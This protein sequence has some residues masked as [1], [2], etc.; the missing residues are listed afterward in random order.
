MGAG[1]FID[2]MARGMQFKMQYDLSKNNMDLLAKQIDMQEAKLKDPLYIRQQE[3]MTKGLELDL[4]IKQSKIDAFNK[5]GAGGG[6]GNPA[7]KTGLMNNFETLKGNASLILTNPEEAKRYMADLGNIA[8][9]MNGVD[10][11]G[12]PYFTESERAKVADFTTNLKYYAFLQHAD[13]LKSTEKTEEMTQYANQLKDPDTVKKMGLTIEQANKLRSAYDVGSTVTPKMLI[14]QEEIEGSMKSWNIDKKTGVPLKMNTT[15]IDNKIQEIQGLYSQGKVSDSF[16]ASKMSTLK[17]YAIKMDMNNVGVAKGEGGWFNKKYSS[18]AQVT[19]TMADGM[20]P[21]S[22]KND[23]GAWEDR[24]DY[25]KIV[26]DQLMA[27]GI[28]LSSTNPTD[29][30]KAK[31]ITNQTM[32]YIMQ[33]KGYKPLKNESLE[34][35]Q[36]RE[37]I[38]LRSEQAKQGEKVEDVLISDKLNPMESMIRTGLT[39]GGG[40][41]ISPPDFQIN[42]TK[43]KVGK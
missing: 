35:P 37:N 8:K 32:A 15:D 10:I 3:A 7:M 36:D 12:K 20:I 40:I 19:L 23:M 34:N 27:N 5:Q 29:V 16:Y 30:E 6:L 2:G 4:Q 21:R 28:S 18:V 39:G 9:Q 26:N 31:G 17:G 1:Y 41:N 11:E 22:K 33:N 24:Y 14:T 13:T 42:K 43:L 25:R 38:L